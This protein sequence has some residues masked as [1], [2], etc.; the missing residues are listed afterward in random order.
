VPFR[1]LLNDE[2]PKFRLLFGDHPQPMWVLDAS[3]QSFWEVNKAATILYGFTR[4]EFLALHIRDILVGE[5]S[6]PL[7]AELNGASPPF[8]LQR[9][10]TKEGHFVEVETAVHE[11]HYGGSRACLVVL[12][13]VTERRRLEDQLRQSQKMEAVGMLAGG[14]AH[15][16]NN[17]LTIMTGYCQLMLKN[18]APDDPNRHSAEQVLKAGERAGALTRQLLAFSRRQVLQP[19]VLD[20]NTLVRTLSVMLHRVIGENI[21]LNLTLDK[22]LGHVNADPGQIE[23]VI[24]NL[25]INARDAMPNGGVLTIET[26]NCELDGETFSPRFTGK[27]G[28]QVRLTVSDTGHGMDKSTR[29]RLFEPFFTTKSPGKGTGLGL[30]TVFGIIKQSGGS[31]DVTS[32]PSQGTTVNVYLPRIDRPVKLNPEPR[33]QRWLPGTGSILVVEDDEMVRS[34]VCETLEREGYTVVDAANP[35]D[36]LRLIEKRRDPI[37][38]LITDIVLPKTSG[39]ELAE[40]I[41][42]SMPSVR[43]LYISGYWDAAVARKRPRGAGFAFLQKPFT[44]GA[45]AQKVREVLELNGKTRGAGG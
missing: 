18:L 22:E 5:E 29:D 10:R 8:T 25:V 31:L 1:E 21:E 9:H 42:R 19:R 44:P 30:S 28:P 3:G 35:A 4:A 45:L 14:V 12:A 11:I 7:A 15:D 36:A 20:V 41:S 27:S 17:L 23:Q 34:L 16:F 40:K 6:L 38:L 32:E 13:N 43:V 24:M 37:D 2:D 26:T 39:H 33:K